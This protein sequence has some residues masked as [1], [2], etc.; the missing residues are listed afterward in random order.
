MVQL[1]TMGSIIFDVDT[2]ETAVAE[3]FSTLPSS[4]TCRHSSTFGGGEEWKGGV[5]GRR[6]WEE[7][8]GSGGGEGL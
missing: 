1:N 2:L 3:W 5:E 4:R 6:G 7:M 8:V